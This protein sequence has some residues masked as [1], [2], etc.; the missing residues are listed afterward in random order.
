MRF[1]QQPDVSEGQ[2]AAYDVHGKPLYYQPEPSPTETKPATSDKTL[3]PELQMKHDK[4]VEYYPEIHFS[5][6]E[7]VV[8]D[9]QRTI[10]GLLLIWLTAIAAF[11]VIL[12]FAATMVTLIK[13]DPFTMF[14][15]VSTLGAI[16]LIGGV[17]GQ[18]VYRQ[19][20]LVATNER[21]IQR[22]QNTPFSYRTQNIELIRVE[23]NSYRQIGPL[24]MILNYGT[25]RFSTISDE[26]TYRFTF[27]TRPVE[28]FQVVN[29]VIQTAN[30]VLSASQFR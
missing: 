24:Q 7:Y 21:L 22:I 28:Q 25:L 18:Y 4:S 9:V 20:F 30:G 11:M 15:V 5:E 23:D 6:T 16:C 19:N 12:L 2:P 8:I 27:V 29:K 3:S 10:W 17:I 14:M 13:A 26:Q 1:K